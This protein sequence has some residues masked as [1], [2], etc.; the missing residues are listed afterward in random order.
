MATK[1]T[2]LS[3][4]SILFD[5]ITIGAIEVKNRIFM[6]PLTRLRAQSDGTPTELQLE[7]YRQRSSAG[8]IISEATAVSAGSGGAYM[9]APSFHTDEQQAMWSR[10]ADAVHAEGGSM[11][12]Q[13]WHVGR[14]AHPSISGQRVLA[15]SAIA[16]VGSTRTPK[17]KEDLIVPEALTASE[18]EGI[19]ADFREASRRAIAAGMDGVEVHAANGYLLHEF[20]GDVSNQRED[21]YGGSPEKRAR[22]TEE[23]VRAVADEIGAE[24][25]GVR[26]SPQRGTHNPLESPENFPVYQVLL[27]KLAD[28][29]LA[30]VHLLLDGDDDR[31]SQLREGIRVPLVL[32]TGFARESDFAQLSDAV[33]EG[34]ADAV[35]VGRWY[36]A[37]PDLVE[38]LRLG[39]ELNTPN[40][41][42]FYANGAEGYTDYP[43]LK[44]KDNSEQVG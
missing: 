37:N 17:G 32:N 9:N 40:P 35:A 24:R 28:L 44:A 18:I 2:E 27:A 43:F 33:V 3:A 13:F 23:V 29:P 12:M 1:T 36:I 4:E 38:R 31:L 19:I 16:A 7:Y 42:T 20:L 15:P 11:F 30:Y 25:V 10:I 8:L 6:A 39:A 26:L 21:E 34:R 22:L 5:P 14:M 41:A